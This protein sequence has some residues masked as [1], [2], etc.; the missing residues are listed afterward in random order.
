MGDEYTR[1]E[2]FEKKFINK[3]LSD[4]KLLAK[5]LVVRFLTVI[6]PA[7]GH[8]TA[9]FDA[10]ARSGQYYRSKSLRSKFS[11]TNANSCRTLPLYR[12]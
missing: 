2:I 6:N 7:V 9:I 1:D 12:F 4:E 8:A 11:P 3:A 5:R 10:E